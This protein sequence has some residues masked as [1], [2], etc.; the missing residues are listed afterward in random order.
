MIKVGIDQISFY[1][2]HYFLDLATL[3]KARGIDTNKFYVGLG[4]EKMSVCAPDEDIVTLA[5]NA[6]LRVVKAEDINQID[7]IFFATETGIDQS[8]AAGIYVKGLLNIPNKVRVVEVK[9]ACYSATVALQMATAWVTK[10]PTKKVLILSADV[11]RYGFN[12]AGE[13]SQ[14]CGAVAMLI[15]AN[16]RILAI[17]A[18]AGIYTDD[19]MDFWRPNYRDEALVEGHYSTK[20]YLQALEETW[21][22]YQMETGRQFHEHAHFCYHTPVP[23]LVEKAHEQLC[24]LNNQDR[25]RETVQTEMQNALVYGKACGNAYSAALYISLASLL[26]NSNN[27]LSGERIGF[28]SYGSGCVAEFFSG[29]VQP[30]Y[31]Q[32]LD[33]EF[34]REMLSHRQEL[35]YDE[36]EAFYS[37]QLPKNGGECHT[38]KHKAGK[39]RLAGIKDHKRQYEA[40]TVQADVVVKDEICALSPG[41]LIL[42]GEHAVVYGKPALAMAINRYVETRISKQD[43]EHVSLSLDNFN[44]S[45]SHSLNTLREMKQRIKNKYKQFLQGKARIRDVLQTPFELTQYALAHWLEQPHAKT[46][47]NGIR[48]QT[49][50]TI[51]VGCGMGSSAASILSVLRALAKFHNIDLTQEDYLRLALEA[52]QLQHGQTTGLDLHISLRGG[53]V[54]FDNGR[55]ETR[56]MP[57]LPMWL[58]NTGTPQVTT[59]ECVN[60]VQQ[61]FANSSIWETFATVTRIMDRAMQENDIAEVQAAVRDNHELLVQ[62]G[63]VPNKVQQFINEL[64]QHK[65]AGKVCGAGAVQGDAAGAVLV[66]GED[67]NALQKICQQYQY[68]MSAVQPAEQG[69]H[70]V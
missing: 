5:A 54:Y 28:Y 57:R 50:S 60:Y 24:K 56:P 8:K 69:L 30:G 43:A 12:T 4:Q 55:I 31:R 19:V 11:A 33:T 36:Y 70:I 63:I 20:I 51:P 38:P 44:Y 14:G 40:V 26:D 6:A 66:I 53:C 29:V 27:D 45:H 1:T 46:E 65:L 3:A 34:H 58:V 13:S 32:Y 47:N 48:I 68:E 37:F 52:E 18:G 16:P 22:H 10:H 21:Q 64:S 41:K 17:E 35:T 7:T 59:G 2:S 25:T 67:K 62:I 42:S 39:F 23:R 49:N 9:Q 15:S 61:H